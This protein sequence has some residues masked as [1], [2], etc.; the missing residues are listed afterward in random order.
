MDYAAIANNVL[1]NIGGKDNIKKGW[2]CATRLRFYLKDVNKANTDAIKATD[3]VITV[4]QS[5]GQYQ[6]VIGNSVGNVYDALVDITGSLDSDGASGDAKQADTTDEAK[7]N[8]LSRFVGFIAGVFTPFLGAMAGAGVFKGVLALCTTM[9]WLS[10]NSGAYKLWASAA[11]AIFYFLPIFLAFTAAKQL[12]VDRYVAATIGAVLTYPDI[13]ALGS[14]SITIHF[15]GI[16][17]VPMSYTSTVI[18][19]ILA[20]WALSY[21]QPALNKVLPGAL[22]TFLTPM[23]SLA[24][25]VPLT[26]IVVGPIGTMI[27]NALAAVILFIYKYV[28]AVA[29]LLMGAFWQV[30]VIFGVHW[31]FVPVIM[32]N[33]NKLGSDPILPLTAVAVLSQAG[34]A[35]AVFLR[36]HDKKMKSLAGSG[37]I[38]AIFGITEPTVYGVTLALKRPFYCA[39]VG[40]GIGGAIVGLM[41]GRSYS[42]AFG[43]V[44]AIPTYMGKGF[45]GTMIGMAVAFVIAFAGTFVFGMKNDKQSAD[46][47]STT[48]ESNTPTLGTDAIIA[49]VSGTIVPLDTVNDEVFSSGAMGKGLAIV[50][51]SDT[52]KAPISGTITALYPTGHAIGITGDN[53][54]ELLIHIGI[55][56]VELKGEHF[57]TLVKK[58]QHVD[59]GAELVHFDREAIKQAGY[60]NTVMVIVTN[61]NDFKAVET[62]DATATNDDWFLKT[63]NA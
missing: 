45:A 48:T 30:F 50:P 42:Y 11:D 15:F 22:K 10:A 31:T 44:L 46:D 52:V 6:V 49:P 21:L 59:Q 57:E 58:N 5:A 34:A 1:T 8:I 63:V 39:V 38:S 35:L 43:S 9:H 41:G 32:N 2:H 3:G 28:P 23:L 12:H 36:T 19:I 24:I 16:P 29:G 33:L 13:V 56:T 51:D 47:T 37:F 7:P 14:K 40:G 60:D 55:N 18:P 62:T 25:M 17:V 4:V 53:G 20:V 61:T 26:L 54:V 27:G